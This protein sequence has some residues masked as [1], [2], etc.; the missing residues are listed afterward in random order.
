MH[1]NEVTLGLTHSLE[2]GKGLMWSG[3]VMKGLKDR[4]RVHCLLVFTAIRWYKAELCV[5]IM[6]VL[7]MLCI[8]YMCLLRER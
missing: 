6:Y 2:V 5:Y 4:V 8:S 1:S 3:D 7:S